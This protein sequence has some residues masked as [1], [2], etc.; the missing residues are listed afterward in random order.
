MEQHKIYDAKFSS[1]QR[2]SPFIPLRRSPVIKLVLMA[3]RKWKEF[4]QQPIML[5][6]SAVPG[7]CLV[8]FHI[9]W[10]ILSTS[11][12]YYTVIGARMSHRKW[13]ENKQQLIR[14]PD[15]ALLGCSLVSLHFQ[16]D[17][18]APITVVHVPP[19]PCARLASSAK[20]PF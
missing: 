15:L 19:F 4:K 20:V 5:P 2:D 8:S 18:L 12:V 16:C 9:L 10:A 3:H 14:W 1:I 13:R 6:G 17:I 7:C 11:T